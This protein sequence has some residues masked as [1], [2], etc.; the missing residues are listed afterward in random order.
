MGLGGDG[1]G[2][3]YVAD[4]RARRIV[5]LDLE[6]KYVRAFGGSSILLNPVDVAVDLAAG[7]AYVADS[8]LHQVVVFDLDGNV[9][10][11]IGKD[12]GDLASREAEAVGIAVAGH[13]TEHGPK[14]LTKNRGGGEAEFLYPASVV[15]SS[16]GKLYVSDGLNGRIQAFD[17]DGTYLWQI[18]RLGDTPGSFARPKGLATDSQDHLYVVDASFNNL[19]MFDS[20]GRLLLA[21]GSV[22]TTAGKLWLP[23][24]VHIDGSDRIYVADRY[25]ARV[26]IFRYLNEVAEEHPATD[27]GSIEGSSIDAPQG[28]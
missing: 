13:A 27:D 16:N 28:D 23:F 25:N 12:E 10:S 21:F 22:G 6:G 24:G 3:V 15:V 5:V 19:Q 26:Q 9:I 7:K 17:R 4:Q 18:G 8:Y 20:Q 2:H 1:D 14:D 11:R